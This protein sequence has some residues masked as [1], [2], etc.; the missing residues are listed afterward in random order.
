VAE[1]HQPP[2]SP[3]GLVAFAPW[4]LYGFASGANHWRVAAGGGLLICLG[5]LALTR[6]RGG[7][8]KLMDWTT[9]MFFAIASAATIG[10]R[11]TWFPIYSAVVVWSCF[12]L[13]AWGSIMIARPFTEAYARQNAPREFW[14]HP[15][16][17]RLNLVLTLVWCALM[18]ANLALAATGVAVGGLFG[19]AVLGF[20]LPSVLLV[21]GFVFN[22]RFPK[23]YLARFGF[24]GAEPST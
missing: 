5:S 13:A 22:S 1:Q 17:L 8:L 9:L 12:A 14:D 15:V 2:G 7:S 19:Q 21:L 6:R 10:L 4:I 3:S 20:A 18:T 16:F 24:A 23:A 11:S